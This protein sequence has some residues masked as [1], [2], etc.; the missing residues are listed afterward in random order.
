MTFDLP[1]GPSVAVL[2]FVNMTGD[3]KQEYFCDGITEN[4]ISA[5]SQ[6]PQLF[7]IARNSSFA[8]KGKQINIK[9][10]RREL[11]A[12][13]VIE[14]SIQKSSLNI[15]ITVQLID[16]RTEY[17]IWAEVYNRHL[18]DII[19]LQDEITYKIAQAMQIELTDGKIVQSRFNGISDIQVY[20]KLLKAYDYFHS[21]TIQGNKLTQKELH[22]IIDQ[23]PNLTVA[24]TILAATYV[25]D[26]WYGLCESNIICF[27]KIA[28][29]AKKAIQLDDS[30]S[31]AYFIEGLL[32]LMSKKLENAVVSF[33]HAISLNPN[34]AAA[35]S[36]LY[37]TYYCFGRAKEAIEFTKKAIDL[38]PIPISS[39]WNPLGHSYRIAKEYEKAIKTYENAINTQP[40]DRFPYINLAYIYNMLGNEREAKAVALKVLE[41]DPNFSTKM[42]IKA[43]P[44]RDE[45]RVRKFYNALRKAGLPD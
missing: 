8:Y 23:N 17:H 35:Y 37:F 22:E 11:G 21:M 43:L 31:D 24:Y 45:E 6:V 38:D 1:K 30:N 14:G 10:L 7:V 33:K 20:L 39:F 4:I 29:L 26:I 41:I 12:Q 42:F 18:E 27:G 40:N 16:T 9:Q 15:R 2:P 25:L 5:L 34:N 13:Y 44:I 36:F 3:P 32:F 19:K 28:K